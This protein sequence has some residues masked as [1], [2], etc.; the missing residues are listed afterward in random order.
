MK[1]KHKSET[2]SDAPAYLRKKQR[3]DYE[4]MKRINQLENAEIAKVTAIMHT[5]ERR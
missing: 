2:F 4:R 5:L 3:S 1:K